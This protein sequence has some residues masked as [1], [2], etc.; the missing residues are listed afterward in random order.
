MKLDALQRFFQLVGPQ[1]DASARWDANESLAFARQLEYVYTTVYEVKYPELKARQLIPVNTSVPAGAESH[2]FRWFDDVGEAKLIDDYA[3]DFP[4]V[5]VFGKEETASIVGLGDSYQYSI[6]DLRRAQL[7]GVQ[8]PTVKA[9]AARRIMERKLDYISAA[10]AP[11]VPGLANNANVTVL[12]SASTPALASGTWASRANTT[13]GNASIVNDLLVAQTDIFT[14][15]LGTASGRNVILPLAAFA[16]LTK[17]VVSPDNG[18]DQ[19]TLLDFLLQT[20]RFD[21]IDPWVA[22]NT[23][24]PSAAAR[25]VV[26]DRNPENLELV[27]PQEFEQLSPQA[28]GM[29]FKVLCHMRTG[30]VVI[31]YPATMRYLDGIA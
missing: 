25:G 27:I 31:R 4:N 13:A 19:R 1:M 18:F 3:T 5:E 15:S 17:R 21:S 7:L 14:K 26:Y 9:S 16:E 11:N 24:G 12:S 2:T 10:G 22:L 20:G 30:G 29:T 8:I 28:V 6:M 23:A